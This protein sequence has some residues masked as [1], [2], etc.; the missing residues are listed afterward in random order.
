MVLV[1]MQQLPSRG[2]SLPACVPLNTFPFRRKLLPSGRKSISFSNPLDNL[3]TSAGPDFTGRFCCFL[4]LTKNCTCSRLNLYTHSE[5]TLA[6]LTA[7][8]PFCGAIT[9]IWDA[10]MPA[11]G[12]AASSVPLVA[13]PAAARLVVYHAFPTPAVMPP[14]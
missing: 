8:S 2:Q 6:A 3:V 1:L 12:K 14:P 7:T 9:L 11:E 4:P 10:G 13:L 5:P